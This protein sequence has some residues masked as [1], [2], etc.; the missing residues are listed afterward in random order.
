[1]WSDYINHKRLVNKIMQNTHVHSRCRD[2][3]SRLSVG[4]VPGGAKDIEGLG[5]DI[6]VD[7]T[8]VDGEYTHQENNVATIKDCTKHLEWWGRRIIAMN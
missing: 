5:E 4:G 6:I 2:I 8:S 3:E 7:E 1:M